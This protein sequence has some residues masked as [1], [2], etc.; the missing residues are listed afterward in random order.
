[1]KKAAKILLTLIAFLIFI[2]GLAG[3]AIVFLWNSIIVPACGFTAIG[4]FQGV[5]LF[6][7]GQILTGGIVLGLFMLGGSIHAL[8]HHHG[9]WKDHWH[10]M[11]DEQRREFIARRRAHFGFYKQNHTEGNAAE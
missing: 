5:G 10:N 4:F 2:P 7:L 1:M 11:T 3:Q 8:Q 6:V 9:K